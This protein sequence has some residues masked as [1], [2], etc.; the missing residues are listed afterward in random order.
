VKFD[1]TTHG[2]RVSISGLH[3]VPPDDRPGLRIDQPETGPTS[4]DHPDRPWDTGRRGVFADD[5][6]VAGLAELL[7]RPGG[8][9][10]GGRPVKPPGSTLFPPAWDEDTR[11]AAIREAWMDPDG[12]R[13]FNV[14][15][16]AGHERVGGAWTG[17]ARGLRI[18][19]FFEPVTGRCTSAWPDVR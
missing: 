14:Y 3:V 1:A 5:A 11:N 4:S 18:H 10:P 16:D 6:T 12:T 9:L 7:D 17:Q 2:V 19:G 15:R 8:D 13:R